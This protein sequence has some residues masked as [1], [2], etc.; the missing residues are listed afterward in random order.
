MEQQYFALY[1]MRYRYLQKKPR[2]GERRKEETETS[3]ILILDE[4]LVYMFAPD[5]DEKLNE[6]DLRK[7]LPTR[8]SVHW[9]LIGSVYIVLFAPTSSQPC[10][11]GCIC[12]VYVLPL[13]RNHKRKRLK[14]KSAWVEYP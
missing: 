3:K 14:K 6:N 2:E 7:T 1:R 12:G 5:C 8:N 4:F 9:L 13:E 10:C 11:Q